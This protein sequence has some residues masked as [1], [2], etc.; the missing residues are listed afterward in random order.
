MRQ[1]LDDGGKQLVERLEHEFM[2]D[3]LQRRQELFRLRSYD[4]TVHPTQMYSLLAEV[5]MDEIVIGI[6]R[7]PAGNAT[8]HRKSGT[9][10]GERISGAECGNHVTS[11]SRRNYCWTSLR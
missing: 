6:D 1:A 3:S 11:G 5:A 8:A 7:S 10:I 4:R 2:K 9:R